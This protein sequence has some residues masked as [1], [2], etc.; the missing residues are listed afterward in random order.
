LSRVIELS[1]KNF[2]KILKSSK[3]LF[4]DFWAPWCVPCLRMN[5]VVEKLA[6]RH[7]SITFAKLNVDDYQEIATRFHI[8]SIPAYVMFNDST[9]ASSK[10]GATSEAE[11]ERWLD[12]RSL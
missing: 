1:T 9:P 6:D 4:V 10:I 3:K 12:D 7:S 8:S 2:D 5:P 11:L